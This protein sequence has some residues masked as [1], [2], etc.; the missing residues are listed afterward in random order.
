MAVLRPADLFAKLSEIRRSGCA[1][2]ENGSTGLVAAALPI[3]IRGAPYAVAMVLPLSQ[4]AGR[5]MELAA[6]L[7][8]EISR[9]LGAMK[10]VLR[11]PTQED[12]ESLVFAGATMS[13][14]A[15][16]QHHAI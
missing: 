14:P 5:R 16:R 1:E 9:H 4:F 11:W 7:R 6:L 3:R 2:S 12:T 15:V 8:E 13:L 10:P